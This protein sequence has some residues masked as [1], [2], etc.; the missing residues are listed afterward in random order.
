MVAAF[1]DGAL[2]L[3]DLPWRLSSP[4]AR[5]P[6]R[7][8]YWE[9]ANG[10]LVAWAILQFPWHCLDYEIRPEAR[11]E[12]LEASVLDWAVERLNVEAKDRDEPL[13][14]YV[15][16]RNGDTP[17]VTALQR[18]GFSPDDWSYVHLVRAID[19][20]IPE[21]AP[22]EGLV[23]RP[24]AGEVEVDAYVA[25]HRAAF[26]STNMTSEWRRETLKHPLYSP[27]L[28]LVA[29]APDG[30]L[31]AFCVSWVT[32]PLTALGGERVVQIE[33]L[34]VLPEYQRH[35]VGRSLLLDALHRARALGATRMEVDA[36]S[37]NEASLGAYESVGFRP[38][39]QAP[40][41]LRRF[42]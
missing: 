11:S 15:S 26:D 41:F 37:Y 35:G 24:L 25:I 20:L 22:P 19:D 14:F 2:H 7:T 13:P 36:E 31:A 12:T 16:A 40:F 17:R 1:P 4:S 29:M 9:D 8:C 6:E 28:D 33:P 10:G 38:Q 27:E 21:T 18:A 23:I 42:G 34:G 5:D 32:P 30:T 39:F 3:A